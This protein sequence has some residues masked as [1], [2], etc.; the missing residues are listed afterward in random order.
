M[1]KG[2]PKLTA[3]QHRK[4]VEKYNIHFDGPIPASSWPAQYVQVFRNIRDI[5]RVRYEEYKPSERRKMI[6][7]AEMKDR[8][9]KLNRIAYSCRKQRENE[10][11]WRGLTEPEIV[12][13]FAAE[14]A[15][16]VP[17]CLSLV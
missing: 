1:A 15:W 17:F 3:E 10:A 16:C 8:V 14:V 12:S 9:A 7:V 5:A 6:T 13:R 4:L 2:D 11:T